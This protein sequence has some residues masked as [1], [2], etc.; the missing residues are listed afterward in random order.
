M[1]SRGGFLRAGRIPR[2]A[3]CC[4]KQRL[5]ARRE[6]PGLGKTRQ[7]EGLNLCNQPAQTENLA[8]NLSRN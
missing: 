7:A 5:T 1:Q 4:T 3:M 6:P 2:L 8:P